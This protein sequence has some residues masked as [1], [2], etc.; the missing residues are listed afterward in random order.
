MASLVLKIEDVIASFF[1]IRVR[2]TDPLR[3]E[4]KKS[5]ATAATGLGDGNGL[6]V[7]EAVGG[8]TTGMI[9]APSAL[10]PREAVRIA[11]AKA[12]GTKAQKR[13]LRMNGF[14]SRFVHSKT[15][16]DPMSAGGRDVTS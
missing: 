14:P 15:P 8:A 1:I 16:A 4:P 12:S 2:V 11:I 5:G 10:M 7:C 3:F 13:I 6:T 9:T